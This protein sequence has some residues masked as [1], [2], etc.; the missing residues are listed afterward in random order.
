MYNDDDIDNDLLEEDLDINDE[1]LFISKGEIERINIDK[2]KK[3][4]LNKEAKAFVNFIKTYFSSYSARRS[5]YVFFNI[6]KD[7]NVLIYSN[8]DGSLF[9]Q[10]NSGELGMHVVEFKDPVQGYL[11]QL[12]ET[13]LLDTKKRP[14]VVNVSLY[15]S[16]L[17]KYKKEGVDVWTLENGNIVANVSGDSTHTDKNIFATPIK[18][19][20]VVGSI[21]FWYEYVQTLSLNIQ[22]YPNLD[23]DLDPN[24]IMERAY[25]KADLD[26]T[27][28]KYTDGSLVFP[29]HKSEISPIL[30]DGV[31]TPSIKEFIKKKK[32]DEFKYTLQ[33]WVEK[34]EYFRLMTK[35]EDTDIYA[36]SLKPHVCYYPIPIRK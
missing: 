24:V 27:M 7:S 13:L 21:E 3:L 8:T 26:L 17:N 36:I 35:Y 12:K 14:Y 32:S 1:E 33:A 15:L 34:G 30:F 9:T 28:F 16:I 25:T 2:R 18:N 4:E 11:S 20:N 29:N 23:I 10:F 19:F 6:V 22:T 5:P 31:G